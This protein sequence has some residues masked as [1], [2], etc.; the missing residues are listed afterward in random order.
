MDSSSHRSRSRRN[1]RAKL[2]DYPSLQV[3][4]RVKGGKHAVPPFLNIEIRTRKMSPQCREVDLDGDQQAAEL[5]VKLAGQ[6]RLL[7]LGHLLQMA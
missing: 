6:L 2:L 7:L 3:E 5:I 1:G 4:A